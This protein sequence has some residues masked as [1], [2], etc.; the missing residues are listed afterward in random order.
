MALMYSHF[1]NEGRQV[2]LPKKSDAADLRH[3]IVASAADIFVTNDFQLYNRLSAIPLED[4]F[5]IL[6]L[7]EFLANLRDGY[8]ANVGN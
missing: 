4:D 3:A 6:R 2:P 7:D 1:Y 8:T 5:K